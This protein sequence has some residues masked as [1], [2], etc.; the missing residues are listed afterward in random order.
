LKKSI[1]DDTSGF[2]RP[3][4]I[5]KKLSTLV[6]RSANAPLTD[7]QEALNKIIHDNKIKTP[8]NIKKGI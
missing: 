3:S 6:P 4:R 7:S 2:P 8:Q 1:N 5:E